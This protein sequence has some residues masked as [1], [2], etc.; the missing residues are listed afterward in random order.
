MNV[1]AE[2]AAIEA[3]IANWLE[4]TNR[5]GEAGADGYAAFVTEDA[6]VLPP[7]AERIDGRPGVREMA[8]GFTSADAFTIS[9]KASRIDVSADG[10]GAHAIGEFKYSMKDAEGDLV[11]EQGKFFDSFEKQADGS[12]LCNVL[13]W[14]SDLTAGD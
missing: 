5:G 6:V 12:W 3:T 14:N 11:S 9:W 13:C 10:K 1:D 2:K 7:N 4:A 8:L